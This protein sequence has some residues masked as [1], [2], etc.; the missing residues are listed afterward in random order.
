[1]E[2]LSFFEESPKK[3]RCQGLTWL[4]V[5]KLFKN[6]IWFLL[7]LHLAF[8]AVIL[9]SF[10]VINIVV[11]CLLFIPCLQF[12]LM[13]ALYRT[14]KQYLYELKL[15]SHHHHGPIVGSGHP[16]PLPSPHN[17]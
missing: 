5:L 3:R 12:N 10:G 2:Q 14:N 7:V 16:T 8:F 13:I 11:S 6:I 1:M 4:Y 9:Y 15:H 17:L